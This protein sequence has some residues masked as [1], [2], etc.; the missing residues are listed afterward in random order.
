MERLGRFLGAFFGAFLCVVLL[1]GIYS[2]AEDITLTTY[3]P[4][5]YGAYK[6]LTVTDK[7]G[8]GTTGPLNSSLHVIRIGQTGSSEDV[9]AKFDNSV[10]NFKGYI[11]VYGTYLGLTE[12]IGF[13]T[14]QVGYAPFASDYVGAA[15][16]VD[17]NFRYDIRAAGFFYNGNTAQREWAIYSVGKNYFRDSV[18]IGTTNPGTYKCY[19]N[20]TGFLNAGAW[21]Y[22]SDLSLKENIS[23]V[24]SGIGIIQQLNPVEFD[25]I[26][27]EKKQVGFIAQEVQKTLPD[28]VMKGQDGLLGIKVD[29]II[30][31][32]VKAMQEQQKEIEELKQEISK[33][34]GK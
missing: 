2:I 14:Y 13:S 30:P 25:Y 8:I 22:S 32:L 12:H 33:L 19:I 20:G 28:I 4:A 9:A 23:R 31:Y 21:V 24:I 17:E 5:P 3:Y 11:S 34:K 15:L 1:M 6:E 27:G 18:G 16:A 7:V 26:N 10:S 29:S